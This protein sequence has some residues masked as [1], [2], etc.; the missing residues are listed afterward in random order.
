[1]TNTDPSCVSGPFPDAN[2]GTV[3]QDK[4]SSFDYVLIQFYNNYCGYSS[5]DSAVVS[6]FQQWAGEPDHTVGPTSRP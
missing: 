1:M 2:L 4:T 6:S 3:L 5:S